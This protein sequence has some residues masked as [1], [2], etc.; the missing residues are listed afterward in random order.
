MKAV[1]DK[2]RDILKELGRDTIV[3]KGE[4]WRL[5][6][7]NGFSIRRKSTQNQYSPE[8]LIPKCQ[9]FVLYLKRLLQNQNFSFI[10]AMDET[11]LFSD[12]MGNFIV[13]DNDA[14]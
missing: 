4:I 14:K 9:R 5:K 11:L 8:N 3:T 7:R 2:G 6:E 13:E 12:N 1:R 10:I